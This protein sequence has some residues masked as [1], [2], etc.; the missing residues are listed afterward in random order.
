MYELAVEA[1]FSAAHNLREYQGKCERLHGHNWRVLVT[2]RS[3]K[4]NRL[5]MVMDFHHARLLIDEVLGRLDHDYLN[6]VK[7]FD[8]VNPTTEN[9]ARV[10]Y[11]ELGGKLPRGVRVGKVTVWESSR[12]GASYSRDG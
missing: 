6:E 2:L 7:P 10:L 12:C 1:D 3:T 9:I 11:E 5:G 4:L 8:K